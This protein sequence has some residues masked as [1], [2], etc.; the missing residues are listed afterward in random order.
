MSRFEFKLPDIGE[1]VTEGEIVTWLVKVGDPI[2]EGKDM[3]EVMTD[4]ATVTIGAPKSGKVVEI[5]GKE[6]ETVPVGSVLVVLDVEAAE[7]ATPG[8]PGAA[9]SAPAA[10]KPAAPPPPKSSPA[11]AA[12]KTVASAVGD[13]KDV[14][15]GMPRSP[16]I[17][18]DE[19]HSDKPLAA[20]ATRKLARELGVDL[21]RVRPT[22]EAGRITRED[23]EHYRESAASARA[24]P[25]PP[26][27]HGAV[28]VRPKP[29]VENGGGP[30]VMF[31]G[32]AP[33]APGAERIPIRGL[34]KRIYENMARAKR[35]AAHFT[36]VDE[37]DVTTLKQMRE[38]TKEPAKEAGVSLTF[39]PFIVK[40]VVAALRR[41]P[42]L[43][44]TVDDAAMEI[45][46][47]DSYDIGIAVATDAGLTVPVLRDADRRNLLEIA[48]ELERL[49]NEARAGK[50][51]REDLGGSSFT[52]TSLGK[53]GGLFATPIVNYPEVAILGIHEIKK[54]PVVRGDQIVIGEVMLL[55][56]SFDHRIIDGH[57]GAAF[58]QDV[59]AYLEAPERLLLEMR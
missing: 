8:R 35:T 51:R 40:A 3:V 20:P 28:T 34:R 45:V 6:G 50:T 33:H 38:R 54:R 49:G 7:G 29:A 39:L 59:I 57:V 56:L 18:E 23:V 24:E 42:T 46:Q 12:N 19:F 22:G 9:P 5:R 4:K 10:Q 21:K 2:A 53:K 13:L 17:S 58:A 41:H 27:P 36:Y 25:A 32:D 55:S 43:N 16:R 48:Q 1:G 37:C 52:I 31:R 44:A 15:P 14:L 47:R 26:G 30:A 11:A